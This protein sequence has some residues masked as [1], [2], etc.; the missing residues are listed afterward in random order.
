MDGLFSLEEAAQQQ[1]VLI[2]RTGLEASLSAPI[3]FDSLR[4]QSL[5]LDRSEVDGEPTIHI[6]RTSLTTAVR[7]ILDLENREII[8]HPE[9]VQDCTLDHGIDPPPPIKAVDRSTRHD[10]PET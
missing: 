1:T 4:A 2:V 10:D 7:F 5:P 8:A 3:S 6:V 9:N